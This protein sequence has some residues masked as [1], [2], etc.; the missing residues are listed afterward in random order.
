ML[1]TNCN[2]FKTPNYAED[3]NE[4]LTTENKTMENTD[5]LSKLITIIS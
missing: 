2:N 3:F 1:F 5:L 4:T